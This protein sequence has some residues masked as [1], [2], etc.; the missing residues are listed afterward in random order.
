MFLGNVWE[1]TCSKYEENFSGAETRCAGKM[2]AACECSGA[3]PGSTLRTTCVQLSVTGTGQTTGPATAGF[4]L[5]GIYSPLNFILLPFTLCGET[6]M[7]EIADRI[8]IDPE[9]CGGRPCIRGMRIRVTDVLE[10]LASGLSPQQILDEM[11]DL[12]AE[13]IQRIKGFSIVC[14]L[15]SHF[16]SW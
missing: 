14:N 2:R 13:D 16:L 9:Q 1:W 15:D 11:P 12:E 3:V 5:P 8:T 7:V 4:V 6:E 10:L